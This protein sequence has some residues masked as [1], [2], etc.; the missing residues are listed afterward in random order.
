MLPLMITRMKPKTTI[1][2]PIH[3]ETDAV[4]PDGPALALVVGDSVVA[5]TR[6]RSPNPLVQSL[7][8][9]IGWQRHFDLNRPF[10]RGRF[11]GH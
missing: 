3:S 9:L 1:G 11:V 8:D 5:V 7:R 2:S 10:E 6:E 4:E